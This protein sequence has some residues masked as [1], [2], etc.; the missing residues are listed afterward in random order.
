M[1]YSLF[2]KLCSYLRPTLSVN[3][4]RSR[5]RTG[6][7]PV[8]TEIAL[9]CLLRWLGGGS[10]LDV[11]L[12]AGI[13]IPYF[14]TCVYRCVDAILS[15]DRLKYK[16]PET[17]EEIEQ[18]A[19]SF[20]EMSTHEVIDG[21]V[22]CVD[23]FLLQIQTPRKDET[24]NVKAYFSGHYQTY[25][26]NVQAACDSQCR[27]IYAAL[28]APGGANDIAAF[29]KTTLFEMVQRLPLGKYIIGDNAYVCT[30]HLLTPF[31]GEEKNQVE[32]DAYN[33]FISQLR[34]R[35]EM[36]YGHFVN[37][38]GVF[39]KPLQ[40]KLKHAGKFFCVLPNCTIFALMKPFGPQST[41][42]G[43]TIF[44][45]L[46]ATIILLQYQECP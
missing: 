22:G 41:C 37:K 11:R 33:F 35:I 5:S 19:S 46:T 1:K 42:Q 29:R 18:A 3:I 36:A 31:S 25:G 23:G 9:H 26:I 24:G 13:S 2:V 44:V 39:K 16:F 10:Y 7:G 15:C 17:V 20:A 8:T 14:Y 43:T 21:C 45:K 32:K 12:C 34:T 6:I 4:Q 27:F 40:V 38:W 28:A 30:E